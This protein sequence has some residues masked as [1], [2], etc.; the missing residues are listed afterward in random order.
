[1]NSSI[2]EKMEV[3][4]ERTN[5][6]R[7]RLPAETLT[8]GQAQGPKAEIYACKASLREYQQARDHLK[9][10]E[11][12]LGET[13]AFI[14]TSLTT[15]TAAQAV[16]TFVQDKLALSVKV[17]QVAFLSY[18]TIFVLVFVLGALRIGSAI[19]RR[20]KAEREIDQMKRGIFDF[21]PPD[22]WTKP[23]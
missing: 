3:E 5:H 4:M 6:D 13:A 16:I 10:A 12:D 18:T 9:R 22:Q 20:T 14:V 11:R 23:E 8:F 21:C 15:V 19:R 17:L 2:K 7:V 1:M